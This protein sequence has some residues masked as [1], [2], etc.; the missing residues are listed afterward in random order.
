MTEVTECRA[1]SAIESVASESVLSSKFDALPGE[2]RTLVSDAKRL[3]E[4]APPANVVD[5]NANI[6]DLHER[7]S[8]GQ[9]PP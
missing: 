7:R 3:E 9:W 2:R 6:P 1:T 5:L 4:L 8:P